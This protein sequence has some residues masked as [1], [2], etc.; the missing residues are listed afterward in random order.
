MSRTRLHTELAKCKNGVMD[1]NDASIITHKYYDR[2]NF[3][4]G[5]MKEMRIKLKEKI[6]DRET[7]V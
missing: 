5:E 7:E 4:V 1:W 2:L 6:I 3:D